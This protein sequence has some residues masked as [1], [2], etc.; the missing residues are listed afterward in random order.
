MVEA[1]SETQGVEK[2]LNLDLQGIFAR[3]EE[4]ELFGGN[5]LPLDCLVASDLLLVNSTRSGLDLIVGD[6]IAGGYDQL[7]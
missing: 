2:S 5:R 1:V 7:L 6:D 4:W 3:S